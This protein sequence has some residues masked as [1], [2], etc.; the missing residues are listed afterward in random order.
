[1]LLV[2]DT[3]RG[4]R[5]SRTGE[6]YSLDRRRAISSHDRKATKFR[7]RESQFVRRSGPVAGLLAGSLG[8]ESGLRR[9]VWLSE[10]T[11]GLI[12]GSCQRYSQLQHTDAQDVKGRTWPV[13]L[14]FCGI[15]KL[16]A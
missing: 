16:L 6:E 15:R 10:A 8:L 5:V 14:V 13:S 3:L 12:S 7:V 2:R 11:E 4:A 9:G 1:M